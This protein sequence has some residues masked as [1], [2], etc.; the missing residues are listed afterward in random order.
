MGLK[1]SNWKAKLKPKRDFKK[2][3]PKGRK[4]NDLFN[5]PWNY[6]FSD[7]EINEYTEG[8]TE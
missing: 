2:N 5:D 4:K 6:Q 3:K 7:Q 8:Q 1:A